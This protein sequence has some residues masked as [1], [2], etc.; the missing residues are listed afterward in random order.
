MSGS[1]PYADSFRYYY[2][3]KPGTLPLPALI[4]DSTGG[5]TIDPGVV[6]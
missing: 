6:H 1:H 2:V 4:S 3:D 5:C